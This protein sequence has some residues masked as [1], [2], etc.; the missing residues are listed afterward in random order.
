MKPVPSPKKRKAKR[1]MN[2]GAS[3]VSVY[4]H[5]LR[6]G[7]NPSVLEDMR[8]GSPGKGRRLPHPW[9]RYHTRGDRLGGPA[10][11]VLGPH[12]S[13]YPAA[14]DPAERDFPS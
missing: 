13:Q 12:W 5:V 6:T 8:E 9:G 1:K 14:K 2:L 3:P 10:S 7:F 4:I 11:V